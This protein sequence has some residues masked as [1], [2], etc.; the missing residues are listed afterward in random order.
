MALAQ[1]PAERDK[2]NIKEAFLS[3]IFVLAQQSA[4]QVSRLWLPRKGMQDI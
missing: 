3:G 2:I 4:A 1:G